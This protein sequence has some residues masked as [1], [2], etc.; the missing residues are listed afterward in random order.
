VIDFLRQ[1][2]AITADHPFITL[3]IIALIA[4]AGDITYKRGHYVG[5]REGVTQR[6]MIT[7]EMFTQNE[8][9]AIK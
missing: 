1:I 6:L 2:T 3:A 9:G 7:A 4:L 8:K 5:Y